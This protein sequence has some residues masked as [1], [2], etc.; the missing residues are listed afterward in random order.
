MIA[1][2]CCGYPACTQASEGTL[3]VLLLVFKRRLLRGGLVRSIRSQVERRMLDK[4]RF[5]V[6]AFSGVFKVRRSCVSCPSLEECRDGMSLVPMLCDVSHYHSTCNLFGVRSMR[7]RECVERFVRNCNTQQL[8]PSG[9]WSARE[10]CT[11][12]RRKTHTSGRLWRS[13]FIVSSCRRRNGLSCNKARFVRNFFKP[14]T[15]SMKALRRAKFYCRPAIK[16]QG[17]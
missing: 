17:T 10:S 7:W 8:K 14:F 15:T 2:S 3:L 6:S 9:C 16:R 11:Q 13:S 5:F 12:K 1:M 4:H